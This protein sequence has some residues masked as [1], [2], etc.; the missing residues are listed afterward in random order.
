MTKPHY[1]IPANEEDLLNLETR[2]RWTTT[3]HRRPST[4]DF[5]ISQD[6]SLN[7]PKESFSSSN[8]AGTMD[9][10]IFDAYRRVTEASFLS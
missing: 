10:H 6:V 8:R 7:P 9:M 2:R 5:E 3:I 4:D 1:L